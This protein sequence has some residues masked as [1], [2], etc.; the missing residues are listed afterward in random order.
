MSATQCV[1]R[2]AVWRVELDLAGAELLESALAAQCRVLGCPR[3][4]RTGLAAVRASLAGV[5]AE[6]RRPADPACACVPDS[7]S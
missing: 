7:F 5:I 6:L 3:A 1:Q 4:E 2:M